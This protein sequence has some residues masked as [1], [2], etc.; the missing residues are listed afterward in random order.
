MKKEKSFVPYYEYLK[1]KAWQKQRL[2]TFKRDGFKCVCCGA[3]INLRA[4]HI[5]YEN[6]GA[7]E[8]GD[9]VTLCKECHEKVHGGKSV[10]ETK[11][12]A[13]AKK[14]SPLT[15]DEWELIMSAYDLGS[16][17]FELEDHLLMFSDVFQKYEAKQIINDF[18]EGA[19]LPDWLEKSYQECW[20]R[21]SRVD[22]NEDE[23]KEANEKTYYFWL[24][25]VNTKYFNFY[26]DRNM[27]E[28]GF[29]NEEAAA[30]TRKAIISLQK[31]RDFYRKL[32]GVL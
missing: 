18:N 9:L 28:M 13:E 32:A 26:I 31:K 16:S 19:G 6:L 29:Q 17:Y 27:W 23:I 24:C 7:E 8:D 4:H 25:Q 30:E 3:S 2:K 5:T 14:E 10:K 21:F 15:G 20:L 22:M 12:E 1:S 11:L